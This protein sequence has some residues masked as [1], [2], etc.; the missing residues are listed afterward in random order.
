MKQFQMAMIVVTAVFIGTTALAWQ[1]DGW[2]YHVWPSGYDLNGGAWHVMN[3]AQVQTCFNF[4]TETW[5]NLR[6]I[7]ESWIY[8]DWPYAYVLEEG[9]WY[10]LNDD[11]VWSFG[12]DTGTWSVFGMPNGPENMEL[13]AAGTNNVVDPDEGAYS[14]VVDTDFLIDAMEVSNDQMANALQWASLNGLI[15]VDGFSVRSATDQKELLDLDDEDCQI[16]WENGSFGVQTNGNG[17]GYPCVEVTWYGACFYC[18][19][20][21]LQKGLTPCYDTNWNFNAAANGYRLPTEAQWEYAARGGVSDTRYAWGDMISHSNAN[22]HSF[23]HEG[24]P[25]YRYDISPTEGYHPDH[26]TGVFP[27]TSPVGSFAPNA[28]GLHD[29]AGN[30]YE[31]CWD[32]FM[33]P[34]PFRVLRGGSWASYPEEC[35]TAARTYYWPD[36][37]SSRVGFRTARP[38]T[39]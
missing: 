34:S 22:Y 27:Y 17:A 35:R 8:Y 29:V 7:E 16:T 6:D 12:F 31:W 5:I 18:N 24:F 28:Y 3:E 30:V 39:P 9:V 13:I 21:S 15:E 26:D 10:G 19:A 11:L 1:P 33:D 36:L 20:V 14:V 4:G 23:W 38:A 25:F 37:S 32:T 2:V